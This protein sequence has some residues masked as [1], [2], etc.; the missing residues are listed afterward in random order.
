M[1]K[2]VLLL[3]SVKAVNKIANSCI[4]LGKNNRIVVVVTDI[5]DSRICKM[6]SN[7]IIFFGIYIISVYLNHSIES[8]V[9]SDIVWQIR[10]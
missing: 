8:V 1:I 2:S 5:E 9:K 10:V 7:Y 4:Y 6:L 3:L